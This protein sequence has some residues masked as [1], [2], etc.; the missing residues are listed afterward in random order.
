VTPPTRN[1]P[2]RFVQRQKPA[3]QEEEDSD[4]WNVMRAMGLPWSFR[5]HY[6]RPFRPISYDPKRPP[7]IRRGEPD[8]GE[9]GAE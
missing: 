1:T 5:R 9:H 3:F 6:P 4:F 7:G 2:I 8:R